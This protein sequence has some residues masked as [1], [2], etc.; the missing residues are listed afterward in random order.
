MRVLIADDVATSRALL[1]SLL[2]NWGYD[3][4]ICE[5]GEEAWE[6]LREDDAP[7]L[8]ILD[9]MMPK[10]DG[11]EVCRRLRNLDKQR[12]T[13][14]ILLT[15][16]D[17]KEDILAALQVGAD[18]YVIKPFNKE[19]LRARMR[20]GERAIKLESKLVAAE[21]LA[22]VAAM[23]ATLGHEIN[24][25]L[26]GIVINAELATEF[27]ADHPELEKHMGRIIECTG[28]I[29]GV[30]KKLQALKY[31]KTEQYIDDSVML[32]TRNQKKGDDQ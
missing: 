15:A 3:I 17:G 2:K 7:H 13:Y 23:A 21:K 25:P 19:E 9:W 10:M 16:K 20:I 14:I 8:A 12:R 22:T 24:N 26:Q 6:I 29:S 30:V 11:L 4:T 18:D 28:R 5:D 31:V 32:S 27:A 1:E